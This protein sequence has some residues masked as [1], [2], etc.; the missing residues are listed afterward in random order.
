MST[1]YFILTK[2]CNRSTSD[3]AS[4][5][6][7]YLGPRLHYILPQ[8][9]IDYYAKRGLFESAL[10]DWCKQY[11]T[12]NKV[13]LDIGAHTGTYALSLAA[14]CAKVEAFEPQRATYYSLCGSIA[15]SNLTHKIQ[16]HNFGL[17]SDDQVG[18]QKLNIVSN[19]GGGSS[20]WANDQNPTLRTEIIEVKTLDSLGLSNIGFVKMDVEDN[21]LSV[22]KGAQE[23]FRRSGWPTILFE[24]NRE[25]GDLFDFVRDEMGYTIISISG[26]S[27]MFLATYKN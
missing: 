10:I 8:V 26:V 5:Q 7:I 15:L 3:T 18:T 22:L 14:H 25:N 1:P 20:L 16:A 11:L 27:N 4:D 9:N 12:P 17:G 2:S 19:D 13:F 6:I 24:S 23:T 21:E